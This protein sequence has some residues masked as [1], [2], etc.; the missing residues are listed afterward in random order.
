MLDHDTLRS[1]YV[2]F[3]W[4]LRL[5]SRDARKERFS[6]NSQA[7]ALDLESAL[8]RSQDNALKSLWHSKTI[9]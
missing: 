6:A 9:V 5:E 1:C 7:L 4:L 2:E 8:Q 3:W